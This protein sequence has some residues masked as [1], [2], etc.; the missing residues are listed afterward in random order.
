MKKRRELKSGKLENSVTYVFTINSTLSKLSNESKITQ[1][2]V[3]MT[4]LWPYEVGAK[5]GKLQQR[6]DVAEIAETKHPDV[7]RFGIGFELIF[8]PF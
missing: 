2:E 7:A 8:S 1:I 3:R 4:M 5:T 6:R